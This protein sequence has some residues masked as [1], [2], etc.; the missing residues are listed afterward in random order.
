MGKKHTKHATTKNEARQVMF[1]SKTPSRK[2]KPFII[3]PPA[4]LNVFAR[5][6]NGTPQRASISGNKLIYHR[7]PIKLFIGLN[8]KIQPY[9][10]STRDPYSTSCHYLVFKDQ[11]TKIN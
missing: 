7:S 10:L 5:S 3:T 2:I 8:P 1:W 6:I 4:K 9:A 11:K